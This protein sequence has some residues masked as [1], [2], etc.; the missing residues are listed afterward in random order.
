MP[1]IKTINWDE[2]AEAEKFPE[3]RYFL[4]L[5]KFDERE[6]RTTPG[7]YYMNAEFTVIDGPKEGSKVWD[8]FMLD[9]KSLWKLRQFMEAC[10]MDIEGDFELDT[11][12]FIGQ[13]VTAAIEPE[14]NEQTKRI[15]ARIKQYVNPSAE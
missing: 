13:E 10:G 14:L 11:D 1:V 15:Q 3:G 6:S 9:L 4:R 12:L 5:D 7:N 2:V 8:I